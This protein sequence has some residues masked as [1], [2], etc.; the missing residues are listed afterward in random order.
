MLNLGLAAEVEVWMYAMLVGL[1]VFHQGKRHTLR[2]R[3]YFR[4]PAGSIGQND[5]EKNRWIPHCI[6]AEVVVDID[7]VLA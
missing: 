3:A 4:L 7:Y 5:L 2:D 6:E 1:G